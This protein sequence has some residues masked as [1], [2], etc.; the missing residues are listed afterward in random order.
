MGRIQYID[1]LEW[2]RRS[3]FKRKGPEGRFAPSGR[4]LVGLRD[5]SAISLIIHE[6]HAQKDAIF[7]TFFQKF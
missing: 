4:F 3:V 5:L 6:L 7:F 2:Q 1:A